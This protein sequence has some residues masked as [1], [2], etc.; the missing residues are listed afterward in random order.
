[1]TAPYVPRVGAAD[2]ATNFSTACKEAPHCPECAWDEDH[3]KDWGPSSANTLKLPAL[4][5]AAPAG[6]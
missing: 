3:F 2:D 4:H 1:M 6:G 5:A